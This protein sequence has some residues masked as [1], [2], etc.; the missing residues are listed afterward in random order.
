M[1]KPDFVHCSDCQHFYWYAGKCCA[2]DEPDPDEFDGV[3]DESWWSTMCPESIDWCTMFEIK[4]RQEHGY[5]NYDHLPTLETV[6]IVRDIRMGMFEKLISTINS[7]ELRT[8]QK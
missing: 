1:K 3:E 8:K 4:T 2:Y 7:K 6:E 5:E